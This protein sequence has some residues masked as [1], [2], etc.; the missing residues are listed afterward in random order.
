[1]ALYKRLYGVHR[2]STYFQTCFDWTVMTVILAKSMDSLSINNKH[3]NNLCLFA[4][5]AKK[6]SDITLFF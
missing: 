6:K 3:E 1:M 5:F 4:Q 2:S